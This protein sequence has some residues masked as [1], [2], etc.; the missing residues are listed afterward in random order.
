MVLSVWVSFSPFLCMPLS[1]DVFSSE[2]TGTLKPQTVPIEPSGFTFAAQPL[3]FF[4]IF[5]NR[6]MS[7]FLIN[8]YIVNCHILS[9]LK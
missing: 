7:I 6:N 1:T 4:V 3:V 9:I 8:C 5:G 2:Q